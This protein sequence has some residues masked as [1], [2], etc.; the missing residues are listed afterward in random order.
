MDTQSSS[1]AHESMVKQCALMCQQQCVDRY[2]LLHDSVLLLSFPVGKPFISTTDVLALVQ[3][4]FVTHVSLQRTMAPNRWTASMQQ[5]PWLQFA[6]SHCSS[7]K[8]FYM[9]SLSLTR[10]YSVCPCSRCSLTV[11]ALL[12]VALFSTNLQLPLHGAISR[13]RCFGCHACLHE[14]VASQ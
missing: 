4:A 13:M 7:D 10:A 6:K 12:I 1:S 5:E 2:G 11:A 14:Q 8:Q 3:K 9:V